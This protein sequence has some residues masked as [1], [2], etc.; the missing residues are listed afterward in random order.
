MVFQKVYVIK[1]LHMTYSDRVTI[2]KNDDKYINK[3]RSAFYTS[4]VCLKNNV[5]TLI[6][7]RGAGKITLPPP[8][9]KLFK[10]SQKQFELIA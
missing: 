6:P 10:V 7:P 4:N 8:P 5:L 3:T 2:L 1:Q 9:P